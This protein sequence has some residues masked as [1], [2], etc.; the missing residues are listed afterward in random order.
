[1][2]ILSKWWIGVDCAYLDGVAAYWEA[3]TMPMLLDINAQKVYDDLKDQIPSTWLVYQ[4]ILGVIF[5]GV[6]IAGGVY[7]WTWAQAVTADQVNMYVGAAMAVGGVLYGIYRVVL[8]QI[9]MRKA[10]LASAVLTAEAT[11][12][13]GVPSP[14]VVL[15][16]SPGITATDLNLQEIARHK[17]I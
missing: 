17:G 16:S 4:P 14:V 8:N 13:T 7:G 1:L 10:A 11:H 3:I 12:A 9:K 5:R 15:P 2:G 6:I